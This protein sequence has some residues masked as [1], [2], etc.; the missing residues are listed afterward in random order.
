MNFAKGLRAIL[1]PVID[2]FYPPFRKIFDLQTFRYLA[3]GGGNAALNLLTF[4]LAYNFIFQQEVV[5]LMSYPVSRYI[6]A[7]L[8]A[9]SISFPIG[10]TLNKFVVFQQSNLQS[11]VQLFRYAFVTV[12]SILFDYLLLHFLVGYLG[13]WA[14]PSQALIIVFLSLYAYFCQT[15]FTF[16]TVK[17]PAEKES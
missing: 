15:Y 5:Y 12:S 13:F 4:Y 16:K 3:C 10:F 14:T 8:L 2:F 11:H 1:L 17:S 7:Y 9:L 6:A